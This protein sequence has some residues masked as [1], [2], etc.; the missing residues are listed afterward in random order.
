[1][2]HGTYANY[3]IGRCRCEACRTA[4]REYERGRERRAMYGQSLFVPAEP[5]RARVKL[6]MSKGM[7][8]DEIARAAGLN[9]ARLSDLMNGHWRT[10]RPLTR[11]KREN[12]E[13]IMAVRKRSPLPGTCVSSRQAPE[14]VLD[15]MALGYS[16]A[17]ITRQLGLSYQGRDK[18]LQHSHRAST[19]AALVRLHGA[20]AERAPESPEASRSRNFATKRRGAGRRRAS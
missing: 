15:L 3:T 18:L 20:T 11:M 12:A 16:A 14:L 6:L 8:Q 5:V 1:M 2:K 4:N 7:S 10:G 19:Y 13:R 17:W 9:D